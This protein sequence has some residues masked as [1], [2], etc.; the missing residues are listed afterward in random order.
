MANSQ[1]NSWLFFKWYGR[2]QTKTTFSVQDVANYANRT[3]SVVERQAERFFEDKRDSA[4]LRW[5]NQFTL[6]HLPCQMEEYDHSGHESDNEFRMRDT[7]EVSSKTRQARR[8]A[9]VARA[10]RRF[11]ARQKRTKETR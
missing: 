11:R 9:I 1:T 6:L 5:P 3:A 8:R 2:N 10:G 7:L 4:W